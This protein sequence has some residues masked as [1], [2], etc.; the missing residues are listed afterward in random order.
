AAL[1][2]AEA[3][4]KR[5]NQELEQFAY[6][7]SHDLQEPLR[8]VGSYT[9]LLARR[10]KDK[11][12]GDALEFIGYAVDGVTRM[13]RL[14]NDLLT[15]SRVG[16]RGREPEPTSAEQVLGRALQNLKVAIEESGARVTHDPLP[17][18]M[19]DD[20]QLEQL[21]QNLVGNAIKYRGDEPPC[22]HVRAERS[23]GSWMFSI[24]DNGIGIEPQYYERVFLI[25]QRLHTKKEY[26]GTGIGLAVCKKIVERHGGRIW[27]ESEPGQGS[28]FMFTLS[29]K[30][31]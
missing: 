18:V 11:L 1:A 7:A 23:N 8:M 13:Q 9:Q 31:A 24:K 19:A 5:S 29:A 26:S 17:E 30:G 12:D 27:V 25:F 15:Y 4:L 14:I 2:E 28:N 20:R 16:T 21:F 22:V 10:Y 6:V 3:D